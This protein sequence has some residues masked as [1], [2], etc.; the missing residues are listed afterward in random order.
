MCKIFLLLKIIPIRPTLLAS[1][2]MLCSG[3][4]SSVG[5]SLA[6]NDRL[7]I[8]DNVFDVSSDSTMDTELALE[9]L[10]TILN[11][12]KYDLDQSELDDYLL[13]ADQQLSLDLDEIEIAL[14]RGPDGKCRVEVTIGIPGWISV[15]VC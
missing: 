5:F 10:T 7:V 8:D 6:Q 11:Y 3:L 15:T 1:L 14:V 2:A 9:Q 13:E 12:L 4:S